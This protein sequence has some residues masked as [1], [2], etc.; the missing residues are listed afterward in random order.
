LDEFQSI[1]K[2]GLIA[3]NLDED[4]ELIDVKLTDGNQDLIMVTRQGQSIRFP[5][6]DVRTISRQA[7]GVKG[8]TLEDDDLVVGMD[9]VREDADLLV[10][11]ELGIGKRTALSEYRVQSRGG[12][13]IKTIRL[14]ERHGTLVGIKVVL[15]SDELMVITAEGVII[16]TQV[17]DISRTGRDTQGV[18]IMKLDTNDRV[19]TLA[20]VVGGGK[21]DDESDTGETMDAETIEETLE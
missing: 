14:T 4:D 2:G 13:G 11:S 10:I 18:R 17:S 21:D 16:R 1:R 19:V 9:T 3:I 12:K 15:E 6:S 7:R 8:I 20:R 5:E